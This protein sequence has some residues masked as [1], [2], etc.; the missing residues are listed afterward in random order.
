MKSSDLLRY[1]LWLAVAETAWENRREYRMIT[2]WLPHLVANTASLLLPDALRRLFPAKQ[3]SNTAPPAHSELEIIERTT[4]ASI[5]ENPHYAGYVTPL[6]LGYILSHPRFNIYKGEWA[7][8]RFAGLGLDALPHGA[9]AFGLVSLVCETAE[10]AAEIFPRSNPLFPLVRWASQHSTVFSGLILAVATLIWESGEYR[11]H[12]Q[13]LRL[14]DGD[15]TK[16]NMQWS[17]DD[18]V[19]DCIANFLGWAAACTFRALTKNE[20]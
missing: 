5:S 18:T 14:R 9:T 12:Q 10:N 16:I 20:K 1:G 19:R 8:K 13:E 4:Q 6:A 2:T 3:S 17:L 7:E 15:I 11:I